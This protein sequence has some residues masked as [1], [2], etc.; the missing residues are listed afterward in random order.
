MSHFQ[1]GSISGQNIVV[2]DGNQVAYHGS[3]SPAL[4]AL[5]QRVQQNVA[6]VQEIEA[7]LAE[8]RAELQ[9][10][11]VRRER[12]RELLTTLAT[13]AGA[14]TAMVESI[15]KVRQALGLQP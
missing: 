10:Q 14:L 4:E 13:G 11:P 5:S 15:D 7:A 12:V 3:W 1:T 2:G 9:R 6:T 8:L